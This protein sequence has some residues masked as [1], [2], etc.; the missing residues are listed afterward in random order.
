LNQSSTIKLETIHPILREIILEALSKGASDIHL[1]VGLPPTLRT[2]GQLERVSGTAWQLDT[3]KPALFSLL[4]PDQIETFEARMELDAGISISEHVRIRLNLYSE[5]DTMGGAL[6]LIPSEAPSLAQLGAPPVL[7]ELAGL[8]SGLVVVSGATGTGK[9]TLLAGLINHINSNEAKHIYTIEDPIEY[10]FKP[11]RSILTQREVGFST[12]DFATAV[13]SSL[14]ADPDVLMVGEMRDR[15]TVLAVLE[16]AETGLLVLTTL[17]TSSA[18]KAVQRILSMFQPSEKEFLQ[19]QLSGC[20]RAIVCQQLLPSVEG[21]RRPVHEI[22]I[23]SPAVREA[24]MKGEFGQIE[25]YIA[26]GSYDGMQAM[27]AT[28]YEAVAAG[29]IEPSV[30]VAHAINPDEMHRILR[31]AS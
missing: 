21:D 19:L 1:K 15:Q 12:L 28:I 23:A 9:T 5:F 17:H 11:K 25:E 31:G 14:R 26:N 16:A 22:L 8:K 2:A 10:V 20:L 24:L 6:R 29:L 4:T 18:V 30:A 27:D 7:E 3:L 13:R